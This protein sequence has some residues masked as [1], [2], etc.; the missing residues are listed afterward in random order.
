MQCNLNKLSLH[1]WEIVKSLI[2]WD[3][4]AKKPGSSWTRFNA[5]GQQIIK[6]GKAN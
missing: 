6:K 5:M 1:G 3:F 4:P 2:F